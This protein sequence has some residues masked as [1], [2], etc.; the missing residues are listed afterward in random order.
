M[1]TA[2]GKDDEGKTPEELEAEQV[3][4]DE[5]EAQRLADEEAE[6]VAEEERKKAE[7]EDID[8]ETGEPRVKEPEETELVVTI[9]DTPA[10]EDEIAKAPEWVRE[11]RK[12]HREATRENRELKEKLKAV[13]GAPVKATE[14]GPKPTLE[15]CDFDAA[16]FEKDLE[17]WHANKLTADEATRKKQNEEREQQAAWQTKLDSYGAAKAKLKVKDFEDAEVV[18]QETLSTVQQGVILQGAENPALLIY[19][20]GKNP[21]KAKE[22]AAIKDPVKFAFAVAKLETQVKATPRKAPPPEDKVKGSAPAGK[23]D[24]QL[25][26]LR[27]EAERT[28]DH[29]KVMAYKREQR[30][31]KAA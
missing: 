4:A 26:R 18:A 14:L 19:A 10:S 20:L 28:G 6:R 9:G 8:P 5:A 25:E 3:A 31:K 1:K 30:Q 16:K 29:S 23:I 15:G 24:S 12:N 13:E 21:K 27:A 2:D 17:A 22:L 7:A 11:L